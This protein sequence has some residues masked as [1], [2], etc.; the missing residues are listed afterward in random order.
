M[1]RG[2]ALRLGIGGLLLVAGILKAHDGPT[3]TAVT[4]AGYTIPALS[5][6]RA[7]SSADS[8]AVLPVYNP[9]TGVWTA[10]GSMSSIRIEQTATLLANGKVLIP[11]GVVVKHKS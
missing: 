6:R 8:G 2:H 1:H 3:S 9:A 10:S 4:I 11:G 5:T 7:I